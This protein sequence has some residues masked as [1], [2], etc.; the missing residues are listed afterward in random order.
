ML[1]KLGFSVKFQ[2]IKL[3]L[4]DIKYQLRLPRTPKGSRY[5]KVLLYENQDDQS[6]THKNMIILIALITL[7]IFPTISFPPHP[8]IGV[9]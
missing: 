3:C 7:L 4:Y 8:Y 2:Q 1:N 6:K 5:V 9:A